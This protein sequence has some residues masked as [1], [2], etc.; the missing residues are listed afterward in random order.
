MK[1][2]SGRSTSAGN[3]HL[4]I[5]I[6]RGHT[7]CTSGELCG[8]QLSKRGTGRPA[9]WCSQACRRAAYEE[10]RAAERGAIAVKVVERVK[11]TGHDLGECVARVTSSPADGCCRP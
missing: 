7:S 3:A 4:K 8:Q 10:R 5:T 1:P 2:T 9:T 11:T 6:R